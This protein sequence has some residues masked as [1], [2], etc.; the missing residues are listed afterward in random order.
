MCLQMFLVHL[1]LGMNFQTKT[2][3]AG[4]CACECSKRVPR[5][6]P[7]LHSFKSGSADSYIDSHFGCIQL[8]SIK[9]QKTE[10]HSQC[11]TMP[12]TQRCQ[13]WVHG[14]G[15]MTDTVTASRQSV[16][17]QLCNQIPRFQIQ[18]QC[19][20][21]SRTHKFTGT[22]CQRKLYSSKCRVARFSK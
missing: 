15:D 12:A 22:T 6:M 16:S 1:T 8:E 21:V 18:Q 14:G 3:L 17:T 2:K 5:V 20:N 7:L 10:L 11:N 9:A 19:P 13:G 4:E